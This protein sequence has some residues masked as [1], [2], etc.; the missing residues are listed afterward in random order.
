MLLTRVQLHHYVWQRPLGPL[1]RHLNITSAKLREICKEMAIPLPPL[2]H[3]NSVRA[4]RAPGPTPLPH[5][6]GVAEVEIGSARSPLPTLA[7]VPRPPPAR[8]EPPKPP[9]RLVPVQVWADMMFG[10]HAPHINTL[11]RWVI[12]GRIQPQPQKIGRKWWVVPGAAYV[13]D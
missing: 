3:W 7:P 2:G 13:N 4:G 10:E 8:I 9:P 5:H 12:D 6:D 11:R 1:S